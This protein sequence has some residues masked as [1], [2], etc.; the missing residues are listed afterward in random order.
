MAAR[1]KEIE[2]KHAPKE[3]NDRT[4]KLIDDDLRGIMDAYS[5]DV[6]VL[7]KRKR[8][9]LKKLTFESFRTLYC[10]NDKSQILRF[11]V[12]EDLWKQN[13]FLTDGSKFGGY[14]L[15]YAGN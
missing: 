10:T 12:F 9:D 5:V 11:S 1:R 14:Y 4:R 3:Q 6:N 8:K 7:A 2:A 13:Y 15:C